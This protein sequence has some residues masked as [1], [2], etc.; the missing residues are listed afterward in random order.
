MCCSHA[1]HDLFNNIAKGNFPEWNF[2]AWLT[3]CSRFFRCLP[4]T[5]AWSATVC[6]LMSSCAVLQIQTMD[7]ADQLNYDFDPLDCTKVS[8]SL[9]SLPCPFLPT[10]SLSFAPIAPLGPHVIHPQH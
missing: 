6:L 9:H 5:Y 8:T 3:A 2:Q 10:L 7:P 4:W 1:T